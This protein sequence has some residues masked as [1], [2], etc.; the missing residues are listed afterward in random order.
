MGYWDLTKPRLLA[1]ALLTAF[2]GFYLGSPA[3]P[4]DTARLMHAMLGIAFIGGACGALNQWIEHLSD[5]R[6]DRTKGRPVPSGKIGEDQALWFGLLLGGGGLTLLFFFVNRLTGFLALFTLTSYLLLYTPL[7]KR[8][9]WNTLAGAVS[10]ALPSVMGVTASSGTAG[11]DAAALFVLIFF[12][13]M[14]HF[15][16]IA[17]TYREDYKRGGFRMLSG[18]DPD[19]RLTARHLIGWTVVLFMA[20]L[21]PALL[22]VA[23]MTYLFM[24]IFFGT[25]LT[26]FACTMAG[27]GL[28]HAKAF[29]AASIVYIAFLCISLVVDKV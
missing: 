12:W 26:G 8:T 13:Q 23:G 9:A 7:K 27:P 24:A 19:G 11:R 14:P 21:S 20:S 16:S 18:L 4:L 15:F 3:G 5:A 1:V 29:T 25:L 22:G 2:A 6:M 10:G 17:W 28:K